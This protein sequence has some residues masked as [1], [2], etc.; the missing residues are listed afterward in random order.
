MIY[1]LVAFIVVSYFGI[2]RNCRVALYHL[3]L[4]PVRSRTPLRVSDT[5]IHR[6]VAFR[7]HEDWLRGFWLYERN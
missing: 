4:I 5:A 1:V 7:C 2:Y 3:H 6:R